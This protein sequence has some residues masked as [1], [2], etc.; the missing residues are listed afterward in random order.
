VEPCDSELSSAS[1]PS[2]N[3]R[4]GVIVNIVCF[5]LR[6][7]L[8]WSL[9]F[10]LTDHVTDYKRASEKLSDHFRHNSFTR[11]PLEA[12]ATYISVMKN[13]DLAVDHQ[14]SSERSKLA[15]ENHQRWNLSKPQGDLACWKH[16]W[17]QGSLPYEMDSSR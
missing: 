4:M 3:L 2:E 10:L 8:G 16:S 12:A 14:L 5:L 9:V 15:A 11:H 6:M 17:H 1:S 13:P 7:G